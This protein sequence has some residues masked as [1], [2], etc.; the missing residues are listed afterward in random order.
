MGTADAFYRHGGIRLLNEW[1]RRLPA[2]VFSIHGAF[3]P[4]SIMTL[5]GSYL[6]YQ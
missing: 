6:E 4:F 3:A 5:A 2:S 1:R